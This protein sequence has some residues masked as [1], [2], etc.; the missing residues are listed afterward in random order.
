MKQASVEL[1]DGRVRVLYP[2]FT[3]GKWEDSCQFFYPQT[4]VFILEALKKCEAQL[5]ACAA[6][7]LQKDAAWYDSA[8]AEKS[9]LAAALRQQAEEISRA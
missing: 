1:V 5:R 3:D 7:V 9:A 6:E 4:A 8:S 2:I